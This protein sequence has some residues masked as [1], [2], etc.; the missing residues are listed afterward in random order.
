MTDQSLDT[1]IALL[2]DRVKFA[3]HQFGG[4]DKF[5]TIIKDTSNLEQRV[6]LLEQEVEVLESRI[7]NKVEKN[8]F[9]PVRLLVFGFAALILGAVI[10][11]FLVNTGLKFK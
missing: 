9:T 6:A 11:A 5:F 10:T 3:L 4:L 2:E 7:S 1:R 8:E